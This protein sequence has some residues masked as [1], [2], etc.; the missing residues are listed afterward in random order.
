MKSTYHKMSFLI[1]L[2]FLTTQQIMAQANYDVQWKSVAK[3]ENE[4]KTK[5]A[6]SAVEKLIANARNE[7]NTVQTVKALLYK[8]K[9]IQVLEENSELKIVEGLKQEINMAKG[10][11]KSILQ[12]ILAELYFQYYNR[13]AWKFSNRTAT[14]VKPSDD[15][16]RW[17][18][19]TLFKE[20]NQ[21]YIASLSEKTILQQIKLD[22]Y[23]P[24]IEQV[25]GSQ[26]FRPTLYDL[27][28]NRAI[29]YFN[30]DKSNIAEPSNAFAID[31]K[32]YF[33]TVNDFI[34]I[35]LNDADK[36]AQD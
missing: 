9:Y 14:D 23:T 2:L 12:S 27:L 15:F 29:S 3:L 31:D 7:S 13:N 25:K 32:K 6:L 19:K 11:D 1:L 26:I 33:A 24:I 8:Y 22:A 20:I 16:R 4:G 5:D 17:D 30:D 36:N 21:Y 34:T 18:L 35:Q 10:A 28:A